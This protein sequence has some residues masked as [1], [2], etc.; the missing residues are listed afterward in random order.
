[1]IRAEDLT[2]MTLTDDVAEAVAIVD[3]ARRS[4]T[5]R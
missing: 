3:A 1:M 5:R 2:L 4:D